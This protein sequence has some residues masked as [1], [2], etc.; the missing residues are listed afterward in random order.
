MDL[1]DLRKIGGRFLFA[2]DLQ[3]PLSLWG[4]GVG[5]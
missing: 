5:G 4:E 1:F 2:D 3:S